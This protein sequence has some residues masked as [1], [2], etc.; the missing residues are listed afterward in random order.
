MTDEK[1]SRPSVLF[2]KRKSVLSFFIM[3]EKNETPHEI[4]RWALINNNNNLNIDNEFVTV[5]VR[6]WDREI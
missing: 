5:K 2:N 6:T 4:K 1:T 3:I